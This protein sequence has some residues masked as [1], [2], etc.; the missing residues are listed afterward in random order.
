MKRVWNTLFG[1]MVLVSLAVVVA[2]HGGWYLL[3]AYQRP[4]H[5]TDV[6]ARGILL[7]L[8]VVSQ[9]AIGGPQVTPVPQVRFV[10]RNDAPPPERRLEPTDPRLRHLLRELRARLPVGTQTFIDDAAPPR[11]WVLFAHQNAW[12]VAPLDL[13]P[14]PRFMVETIGILLAAIILSVFAAWQLQRPVA[15]IA[16][17]ARRFGSGERLPP[18]ETSG[19]RELRSLT[20]SFNEMMKQISDA[21]RDQAVMIA[22]VAH[23]LKAPLT[24]MRLRADVLATPEQRAAF[25]RD[26]DSLSTIVQQFLEFADSGAGGGEVVAVDTFL[27]EQFASDH[28]DDAQDLFDLSLQAGEGF[29]LPRTLV[30]RLVTNLVDN[31]LEHGAPPV[32]ICTARDGERWSVRVRD[33]G[34]GIADADLAAAMRPFV[35]LDPARG[36]DAHCGLGLAIVARLAQQHGGS[37]QLAN[38]PDGGLIA[39]IGLPAEC[40][41]AVGPAPATRKIST[42]TIQ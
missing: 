25:V 19:P 16:Q 34:E 4:R 24:R 40:D 3:T 36:G 37:L 28:D 15:R 8:D 26:I 23:D 1:R 42:V 30:D 22:G 2:V 39:T 33:H 5:D 32:E 11:L 9:R 17:A 21:E 41:P 10:W 18:V 29:T 12:I 6:F 27:R 20:Q 31:A 14:V 7:M 38:A 13:P 35:R